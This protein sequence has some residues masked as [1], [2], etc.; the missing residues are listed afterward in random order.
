M[1]DF[2]DFF[3][4]ATIRFASRTL[5]LIGFLLIVDGETYYLHCQC[6]V[7]VFDGI[8]LIASSG[9]IYW[10]ETNYDGDEDSWDWSEAVGKTLFDEQIRVITDYQMTV[11]NATVNEC[12]DIHFECDNGIRIEVI[13]T[14]LKQDDI[15]D[16][17]WRLFR[18][19]DYDSFTIVC[20]GTEI[21]REC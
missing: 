19:P 3:Q 11:D 17:S 10:P 7:R 12:G 18:S 9:D 21:V 4:N 1:I 8:K 14:S 16:E 15:W 6:L 5:N 2:K 13:V 20:N